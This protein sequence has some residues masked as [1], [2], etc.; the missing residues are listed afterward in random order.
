M[1]LKTLRAERMESQWWLSIETGI[2][3][4]K[5]SLFERGYITPSEEEK[6][7]IADALNVSVDDIDW[8]IRRGGE[9]ENKI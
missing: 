2:H 9:N 5:I 3:Q 1:K 7:K 8:D 6:Q 4:S